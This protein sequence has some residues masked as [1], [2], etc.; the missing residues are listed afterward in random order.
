M[1]AHNHSGVTDVN[2]FHNHS[3]TLTSYSYNKATSNHGWCGDD[4]SNG[5]FTNYT[6][7]NGSH[8]HGL[9]INNTGGNGSH[10]NVQP[11]NVVA[12]W[13]RVA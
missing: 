9:S 3:I 13:K 8:S 2:G 7:R 10:N 5:N 1:P 11:Y 6:D 12:R 4:Y